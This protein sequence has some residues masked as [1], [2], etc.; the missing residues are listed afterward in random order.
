MNT[1]FNK[2]TIFFLICALGVIFS[3]IIPHIPNF[4]PVLSFVLFCGAIIPDKK[5]G[6]I[7]P[8]STFA[9]SDLALEYLFGYGFHT[10]MLYIYFSLIIIAL[11]GQILLD[12]KNPKN[13]A[14]ISVFSS[15]TFF[16]FS[17]LGVFLSGGYPFT[18]DGLVTCYIMAIPFF[19]NTL[20]S[21]IFYSFIFFYFYF[22]IIENNKIFNFKKLW[23]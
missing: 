21:T 10:T 7:L 5:F 9:I 15:C 23:N 2:K 17:N 8:L 20:M 14:K 19:V 18:L 12:I 6:I 11:F 16:I 3:R 22:Y 4:T 1:L 13:L